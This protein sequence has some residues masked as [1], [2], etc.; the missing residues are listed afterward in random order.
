MGRRR[1]RVGRRC[2]S[3]S[4]RGVGVAGEYDG[5]NVSGAGVHCGIGQLALE[6]KEED[7]EEVVPQKRS[8][9][10]EIGRGGR[11]EEMVIEGGILLDLRG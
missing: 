9:Q 4:G 10:S 7:E 6:M 11:G 8:R 3:R 2:R 5:G 1:L